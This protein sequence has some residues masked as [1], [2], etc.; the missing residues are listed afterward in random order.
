MKRSLHIVPHPRKPTRAQ[1]RKAVELFS[2]EYVSR[3]ENKALR[4]KWLIATAQLGNK[5]LLAT[6]VE[7]K[8]Q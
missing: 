1:L 5:S 7:R 4:V 2:S 8:A 3:E 6:P